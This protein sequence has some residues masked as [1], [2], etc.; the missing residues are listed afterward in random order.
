MQRFP[1]GEDIRAY[2]VDGVAEVAD[3]R[4]DLHV[5]GKL[6]VLVQNRRAPLLRGARARVRVPKR[7]NRQS[8]NA[9]ASFRHSRPPMEFTLKRRTGSVC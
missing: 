7:R 3:A 5:E 6:F 1:S 2:R 4:F 8:P 9:L